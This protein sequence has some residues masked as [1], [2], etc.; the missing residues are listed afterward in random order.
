MTTS[1]KRGRRGAGSARKRGDRW[2]FR[3]RLGGRQ[4]SVYGRTLAEARSKAQA[5]RAESQQRLSPT[6]GDWL[7]Q[8][9]SLRRDAWRPQT[10]RAYNMYAQHHIVPTIGDVP[11]HALTAEHIDQL[12]TTML[13]T[14]SATTTRHAHD[15]LASA[16]RAATRRG[17]RV[18]SAIRDVPPPRRSSPLIETLTRDEVTRLINTAYGDALEAAYVLAVTLGVRQG[19]LRGLRWSAVQLQERRLVVRSSATRTLDNQQVISLP[20][21]RAG[22]TLRLPEVAVDALLRTQRRGELVWPGSGGDPMPASSFCTRWAAMRR[23]AGIRPVHF[24]ALRHTA[25]TL[26]LEDGVS[27]HVVAAML[28][29]ASVA[30]TLGAY[31]HVTH[32]SLDA[33][34]EAI[35][36]R[37]HPRVDLR[38]ISGET[39]PRDEGTEL[40]P[41][42][43]SRGKECRERES[44]LAPP[45][46][47]GPDGVLLT[48]ELAGPQKRARGVV[49]VL[50]AGGIDRPAVST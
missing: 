26:A 43:P 2:E 16:L 49:G 27:P 44:N 10:W 32:V 38:V 20:K 11:I 45:F 37:H 39:T 18:P 14:V 17:L 6:V 19:E 33:L 1:R 23:R 46:G 12:H 5:T 9:L 15:V 30:T 36:S 22:R 29:H 4:H 40:E 7:A 34:T 3:F 28:G 41:R 35:N 47:T 21:T 31:A 8:W 13:R 25:A 48:Y 42:F 24:H 50:G